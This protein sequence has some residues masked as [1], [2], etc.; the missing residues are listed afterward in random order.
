MYSFV[1]VSAKQKNIGVSV[2]KQLDA[3][4][5][6]NK[7]NYSIKIPPV[8]AVVLI[9]AVCFLFNFKGEFHTLIKVLC[10]EVNVVNG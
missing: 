7:L 5:P 8:S 3:I 6:H 10:D 2:F 1:S 9:Q 4:L